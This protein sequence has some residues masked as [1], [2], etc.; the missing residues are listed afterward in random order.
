MDEWTQ[1]LKHGVVR[2][3][4]NII[5]TQAVG[6]EGHRVSLG[7][8]QGTCDTTC[9]TQQVLGGCVLN[10]LDSSQPGVLRGGGL[11]SDHSL[12]EVKFPVIVSL[13]TVTT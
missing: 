1:H 13:T 8:S 9:F 7:G 12:L 6:S 2:L 10:G 11:L 5:L 3:S 4:S